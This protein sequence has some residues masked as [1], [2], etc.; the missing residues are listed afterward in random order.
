MAVVRA[1]VGVVSVV[2]VGVVNVV[3]VPVP[4]AVPER[5]ES[6]CAST[7]TPRALTDSLTMMVFPSAHGKVVVYTVF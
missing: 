1:V 4:V 7:V 2:R 3:A 6:V 5:V